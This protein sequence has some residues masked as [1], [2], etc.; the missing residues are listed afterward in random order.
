MRFIEYRTA[1]VLKCLVL[2][3]FVLALSL[4][5]YSAYLN[6][7][8]EHPRFM[9]QCVADGYSRTECDV[10]WAEKTRVGD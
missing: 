5:I 4:I 9:E 3:F 10:L 7:T 8:V 1:L 6:V 2:G